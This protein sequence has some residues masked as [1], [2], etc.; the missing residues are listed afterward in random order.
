MWWRLPTKQFRASTGEKNRAALRKLVC[1]NAV[2]G[3]LA[4]AAGR[5]I[6]WCAV[7]P[8][9]A[10]PRLGKSRI[11][12]PVDERPVWSVTCFFVAREFRRKRVTDALLRAAVAYAHR[13]GATTVE[14]Y[15]HDL[16]VALPDAFVYTGLLP[17]FRR[18]GF[19]VVARRS[20]RRP[21]VRLEC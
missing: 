8:R 17:T 2:P 3:V 12:K 20:P 4:Y 5:P 6:G 11:L 21:I 9:E 19:K 13:E 1:S 15:P 14:A 18:A 16:E 7:A 10:Y